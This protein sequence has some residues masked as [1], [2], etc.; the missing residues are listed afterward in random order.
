MKKKETSLRVP[1]RTCSP[2]TKWRKFFFASFLNALPEFHPK[3]EDT[4]W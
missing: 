3:D 2:N 1:K 4:F